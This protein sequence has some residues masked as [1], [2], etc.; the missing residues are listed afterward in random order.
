MSQSEW[1]LKQ[2]RAGRSLNALDALSGCRCFR[3]AARI[4]D[5]RAAG[6][7]IVTTMVTNNGKRYGTYTLVKGKKH[8]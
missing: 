8:G 6:H 7:N 5:L 4:D 3:L 2:L 1:I